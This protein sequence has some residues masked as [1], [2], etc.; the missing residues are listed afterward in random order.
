MTAAELIAWNDATARQWR[1]LCLATPAILDA[2]CDVAGTGTCSGLLRHLSIT[3][4]RYAE[5]LAGLPA[6]DYNQVPA[7]TSEQIFAIHDHAVA[8]LRTLVE[9]PTIDWAQ[10]IEFPT[11]TAGR[12]LAS[13]R[14]ILFHA[15][16]HSI[17]HYAQL[18]TA[19]RR[20]GF[21]HSLKMDYLLMDSEPA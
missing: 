3:E 17:R 2:P 11:I 13:R 15:M 12:R 10:K 19:V 18:G 16:L 7:N 5:L 6:G 21:E 8:V 4:L 20:A 1:D 9:D 14:A